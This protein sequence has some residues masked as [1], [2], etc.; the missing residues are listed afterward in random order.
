LDIWIAGPDGSALG[1]T[2]GVLADMVGVARFET[3][4]LFIVYL[5]TLPC[6]SWWTEFQREPDVDHASAA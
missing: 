5:L 6:C 4:T 1:P 2:L 3:V